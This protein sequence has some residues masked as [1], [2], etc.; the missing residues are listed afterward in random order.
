MEFYKLLILA[1]VLSF[2]TF[3]IAITLGL[4][5]YKIQFW[6]A[7]RVAIVFAIVQALMPLIGWFGGYLVKDYLTTFDHW[8]SFILLAIVGSKMIFEGINSKN[9][10]E[11]QKLTFKVIIPLSFVT[12]I[13]AFVVGM[14]FAFIGSIYITAPVVIGFITFLAAML[15]MLFGKKLGIRSGQNA[16]I[17]GG[18]ILILL[19]LQILFEHLGAQN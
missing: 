13:D 4:K 3:A 1:L 5:D 15:G 17:I 9:Q 6:N 10:F 19:G 8:I 11:D 18:I 7:T 14:S 16:E 12:S 2:D